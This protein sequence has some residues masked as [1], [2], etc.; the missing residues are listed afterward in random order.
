MIDWSLAAQVARGVAGLQQLGDPAPFAAPAP[1][2]AEAERL[3]SA[4]TGLVAAA[5]VPVAEAVARDQWIEANLRSLGGVLDPAVERLGAKAGPFAGA[6]GTAAGG[7]LA[8]EAGAVSG[9]LAGRV[10]GQYEFPVL[11]PSAP[12]RLL[13]VAPNL[14]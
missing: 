7:L 8:I 1:P 9:F 4:Y 14:G 2:S 13:F 11:D 5:P 6:L 3:V 10:L 12:A